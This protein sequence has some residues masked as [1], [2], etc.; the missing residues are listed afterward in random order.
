[1]QNIDGILKT[2][3]I[4]SPPRI[5]MVRCHNFE[6]AGT[7]K[8]SE[9]LAAGSLLPS[10]AVTSACP[11]SILTELGKERKSLSDV[12]IHL[13]GFSASS[14]YINILIP[15]CCQERRYQEGQLYV[16][17]DS[18]FVRYRERV[19]QLD[20]SVKDRQ[21]AKRLGSVKDYPR[22][23]QIRPLFA[24]FMRQVNA[25]GL[26]PESCKTLTDFVENCYLKYIEEKRA[27]T[28]KG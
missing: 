23:S 2:H 8:A 4:D 12:P 14:M 11:M 7:A 20:G 19:Q 26:T 17:H 3:R 6:H 27:S 25:G 5:T 24:E 9:G 1:V 22:E 18:W 16:H 15:I 21:R 10:W 13:T 28:K